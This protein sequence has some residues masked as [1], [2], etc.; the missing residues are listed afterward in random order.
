MKKLTHLILCFTLFQVVNGQSPYFNNFY[1]A[2][3]YTNPSFATLSETPLASFSYNN[4]MNL[5][6]GNLLQVIKPL[7]KGALFGSFLNDASGNPTSVVFREFNIGYAHKLEMNDWVI[8]AGAGFVAN[9]TRINVHLP[10]VDS[11]YYGAAFLQ[12]N[13]GLSLKYKGVQ[14]GFSSKNIHLLH[15]NEYPVKRQPSL[16]MSYNFSLVHRIDFSDIIQFNYALVFSRH[17]GLTKNDAYAALRIKNLDLG[18]GFQFVL[19]EGETS[20]GVILYPRFY[21]G[22]SVKKIRLTY[23]YLGRNSMIPWHEHE[24]GLQLAFNTKGKEVSF[25]PF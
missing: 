17:R 23:S 12:G 15:L 22:Y 14:L 4:N 19:P 24:I 25:L 8:S 3:T 16:I 6:T 18:S 7:K 2:A 10:G 11:S 1:T 21:A 13:L 20:N 9:R 5:W